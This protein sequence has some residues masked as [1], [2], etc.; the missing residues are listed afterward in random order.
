M[1]ASL[2]RTGYLG[3]INGTI[4]IALTYRLGRPTT[5]PSSTSSMPPSMKTSPT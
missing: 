1:K 3:H 5:R 2:G 4:V